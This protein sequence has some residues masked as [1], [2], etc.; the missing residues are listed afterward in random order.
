MKPETKKLYPDNWTLISRATIEDRG[1]FCSTCKRTPRD[2]GIVLTVHHIDYNP[3]NNKP[4]NL[5]VL[6]QGCHLRC[7]AWDLAEATRLNKVLVLMRMGQLCFPGLEPEIPK[8]LDRVISGKALSRTLG[9]RY[10][11]Q[12]GIGQGLKRAGPADRD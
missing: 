3:A 8:R 1:G 4:N 6:C 10:H 12:P 5:V 7:Q 11:A 9:N 2:H